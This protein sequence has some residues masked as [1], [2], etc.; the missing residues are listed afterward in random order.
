MKLEALKVSNNQQYLLE[1][2]CSI[3]FDLFDIL[4][5]HANKFRLFIKETLLIKLDQPHL[6][7]TIKPFPL[8]SIR[9]IALW[10]K[11]PPG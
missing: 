4:V 3:D 8:E 7:K 6:N 10:G 9:T 1:C 5:S 11:L 2:S